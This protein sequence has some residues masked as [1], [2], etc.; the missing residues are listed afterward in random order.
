MESMALL[1]PSTGYKAQAVTTCQAPEE[2]RSKWQGLRGLLTT[3]GLS[4]DFLEEVG[5]QPRLED[6]KVAACPTRK[7]R[8][9]AFRRWGGAAMQCTQLP[10]LAASWPAEPPLTQ[11]LE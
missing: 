11:A 4:E 3:W 10:T 1:R 5:T 9:S 8:R 7:L 2:G 6:E